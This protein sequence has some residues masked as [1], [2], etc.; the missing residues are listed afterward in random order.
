VGDGMEAGRRARVTILGSPAWR[1]ARASR[2]AA[3]GVGLPGT[4]RPRHMPW[5]SAALDPSASG[6]WRA[7]QGVYAWFVARVVS[8]CPPIT[9][10]FQLI[11]PEPGEGM[12]S[13]PSCGTVSET[14]WPASGKSS[15][16]PTSPLANHPFGSRVANAWRVL[17]NRSCD[18]RLAYCAASPGDHLR[19]M[20]ADPESKDVFV[21]SRELQR[22][23]ELVRRESAQLR[24]DSD[25]L[26]RDLAVLRDQIIR[27][28]DWGL[29]LTLGRTS[30][31]R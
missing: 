12:G 29:S 5:A 31:S 17:A 30:R 20:K 22:R 3:A 23:S 16:S 15:S 18:G 26:R 9:K 24:S 6:S 28:R 8:A 21:R 19:W 27:A 13:W 10:I 25:M 1:G 14:P 11:A 2:R 4:K 7:A